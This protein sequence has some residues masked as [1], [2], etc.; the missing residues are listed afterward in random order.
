MGEGLGVD[1]G[2]GKAGSSMEVRMGGMVAAL[3]VA[4]EAAE[5]VALVEVDVLGPDVEDVLVVG[6]VAALDVRS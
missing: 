1:S 5:E 6:A 4:L 2:V 3:V